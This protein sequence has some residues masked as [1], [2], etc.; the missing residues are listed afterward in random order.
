[1][2]NAPCAHQSALRRRCL[3]LSEP[4]IRKGREKGHAAPIATG[5]VTMM[6]QDQA[7]W[8]LV[9][10]R[11][12]LSGTMTRNDS[13]RSLLADRAVIRGRITL[14]SG[15]ESEYYFDCKRVMLSSDG[16]P[17]VGEAFLDAIKSLPEQPVAIGGLT[18][19]AD[20]IVGAAMMK[21]AEQGLHLDGFYVR[22]EPKKHG[23]QKLIENVPESGTPVVIVDDVVTKG[24]SVVQAIDG[25]EGAG[26]RVVAV[27]VLIDRLEGGAAKIRARA[28]D[29]HYI[30]I[31]TLENFF[32]ID[33][34]RREWTKTSPQLSPAAST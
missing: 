22:K 27:I 9:S 19:G 25:A 12:I 2:V 5:T 8:A 6:L 20:P 33:E 11:V 24:G 21:A 3:S 18:H 32:D 13:L 4:A 26:C 23:T 34:I 28:P 30:T 14:S 10:V 31:F 15:T 16:A 1:V 29:A 17:L 7:R